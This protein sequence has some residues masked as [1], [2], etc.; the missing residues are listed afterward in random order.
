M[1]YPYTIG[2]LA[3]SLYHLFAFNLFL[4]KIIKMVE[5]EMM[6]ME[7]QCRFQTTLPE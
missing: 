4:I 2:A 1:C 5:N 6:S 3:N 7:V